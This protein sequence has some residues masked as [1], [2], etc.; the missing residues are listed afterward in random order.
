MSSPLKQAR[1]DSGKT[2]EEISDS[3]KIRKQYLLALE[4]GDFQSMPAAV[5]VKGYLKLYANYLGII[6]TSS[7]EEEAEEDEKIYDIPLRNKSELVMFNHKWKKYLIIIS[8][9]ILLIIQIIHHLILP[10]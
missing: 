3:L 1:L 9:L 8:I 7:K 6:V 2:L 4:E 5:Y 10:S